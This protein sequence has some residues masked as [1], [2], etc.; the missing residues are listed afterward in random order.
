MD[1]GLEGKTAL[2]TA[3]SRGIGR[4][5]ATEFATEGCEVII[6]SRNKENLLKTATQ[7]EDKTQQ[8]VIA[9]QV[10]LSS[11]ESIQKF[12]EEIGD[13]GKT[14]D[15]L[16][17][18][19][20]GPPYKRH[21]ELTDKDWQE[22]FDL[23]FLSQVKIS[24][25]MIP[26]MKNKRWGRIIFVTSVAVKQPGML[27]AN[28]QRASLAAYAKTLSNELGEYNILVNT[29]CP[30]FAVTDQYY[31]IADEVARRSGTSRD[32]V[33]EEW[34]KSVPLKRPASTTEIANAA[35]FLASEKASYITGNCI[36][37]DGGFVKSLF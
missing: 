37:V 12:L 18:N 35:V 27:I 23:T 22:S 3:S 16:V 13:R 1:L 30:A 26:L 28:S 4:A 6:C 33:I 2:I 17:N 32:K 34:L 14:I 9:L 5:I 21:Y 36:Q 7:I 25:A 29:I 31:L 10:D 24:E 20:G 11:Q 15:I 8:K 19:A